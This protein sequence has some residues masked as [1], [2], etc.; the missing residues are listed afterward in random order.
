MRLVVRV[1]FLVFFLLTGLGVVHNTSAQSNL[2]CIRFTEIG[3]GRSALALGS[4]HTISFEAALNT[5]PPSV[6]NYFLN[7]RYLVTEC[8]RSASQ[9]WNKPKKMPISVRYLFKNRR[10]LSFFLRFSGLKSK[11]LL[12]RLNQEQFNDISLSSYYKWLIK[13]QQVSPNSQGGCMDLE[14]QEICYRNGGSIYALDDR[15]SDAISHQYF[16]KTLFSPRALPSMLK[17]AKSLVY[18]YKALQLLKKRAAVRRSF[19]RT[20]KKKQRNL[21]NKKV[22]RIDKNLGK[23]QARS[24]KDLGNRI[25]LR[26][27]ALCKLRSLQKQVK[28]FLDPALP[29][30]AKVETDALV[31]RDRFWYDKIVR[32][33]QEAPSWSS[34]C[35]MV[36]AAHLGNIIRD[37]QRRGYRVEGLTPDGTWVDYPKRL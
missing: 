37:M 31:A 5:L 28:A 30:S 21:L 29:A 19:V 33:I 20:K 22:K 1:T 8:G 16:S 2:E 27:Q 23:L 13:L 4:M 12:K 11:K 15:E 25:N 35:F 18:Y 34:P 6:R 36:G 14:A 26:K 3:T 32:H 17:K 24:R 9:S 7:T 10:S